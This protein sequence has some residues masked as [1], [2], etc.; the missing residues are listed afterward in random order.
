[1]SGISALMRR[2]DPQKPP[3][4]LPHEAAVTAAISERELRDRLVHKPPR[5]VLRE[6]PQLMEALSPGTVHSASL[7]KCPPGTEPCPGSR[8][9]VRTGK[10]ERGLPCSQHR[11]QP[12]RRGAT[13]LVPRDGPGHHLLQISATESQGTREPTIPPSLV[14]SNT[15]ALLKYTHKEN[16][17]QIWEA[18][19]STL[20]HRP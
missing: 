3:A 18:W 17:T 8:A 15:V 19:K 12:E 4:L 6:Q 1:M 16:K 10:D 5:V 7:P 2:A 14:E 9:S 13:Q 11:P 20:P